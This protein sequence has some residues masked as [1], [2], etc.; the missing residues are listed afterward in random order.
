MSAQQGLVIKNCSFHLVEGCN[1]STR[2]R[3]LSAPAHSH[4]DAEEEGTQNSEDYS[5]GAGS[6]VPYTLP[7]QPWLSQTVVRVCHPRVLRS[8]QPNITSP[9]FWLF[10]E[11][12]GL[13]L[14]FVI[15]LEGRVTLRLKWLNFKKVQLCPFSSQMTFWLSVGEAHGAEALP[16]PMK[17]DFAKSCLSGAL[18]IGNFKGLVHPDS[19]AF[20]GRLAVE[21]PWQ[22][23][24]ESL[25]EIGCPP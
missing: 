10:N 4:A 12:L 20:L 22:C 19:P 14:R 5:A 15:I 7:Y 8:A 13:F 24:G 2:R 17:H 3:S 18:P 16:S 1:S 23:I 11:L 6:I 9:K 21:R 25:A